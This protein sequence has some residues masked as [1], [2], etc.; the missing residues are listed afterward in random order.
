MVRYIGP[1]SSASSNEAK[2]NIPYRRPLNESLKPVHVDDFVAHHTSYRFP[3]PTCLCPIL[4]GSAQDIQCLIRV[5]PYK[6]V[7]KRL[8]AI[9]AEGTCGYS[10]MYYLAVIWN[11]NDD[12]AVNLVFRPGGLVQYYPLRGMRHYLRANH[13]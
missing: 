11:L 6:P 9:C 5:S 7:E 12:F 4:S 10:G 2:H 13:H 1:L 8:A 3:Y